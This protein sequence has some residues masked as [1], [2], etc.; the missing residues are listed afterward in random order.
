MIAPK[1]YEVS[2]KGEALASAITIADTLATF[3][4]LRSQDPSI[5]RGQLRARAILH[6]HE[7]DIEDIGNGD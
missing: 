4:L 5:G 1:A 3:R 2:Y 6:L 7:V